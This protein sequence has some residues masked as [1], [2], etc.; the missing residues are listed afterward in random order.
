VRNQRDDQRINTLGY[1]GAMSYCTCRGDRERAR[2][3]FSAGV[4]ATDLGADQPKAAGVAAVVDK[5]AFDFHS[6]KLTR[7]SVQRLPAPQ[8]SRG[9]GVFCGEETT[10]GHPKATASDRIC[11]SLVAIQ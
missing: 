11:P 4:I 1:V 2:R 7:R 5:A 3:R 8:R 6:Q 9:S 10:V